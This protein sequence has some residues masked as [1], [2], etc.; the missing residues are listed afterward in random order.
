MNTKLIFDL[1][2]KAVQ[3]LPSIVEAGIDIKQRVDDIGALAKAA[4]DGSDTA[5][6]VRKVRA[7]LDAD[8]NEFNSPMPD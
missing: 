8:L 2:A 5:E 1:I 7:Q 4:H 6:L 3:V